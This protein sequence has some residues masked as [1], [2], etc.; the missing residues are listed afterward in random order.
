LDLERFNAGMAQML[1]QFSNGSVLDYI[2]ALMGVSRLPSDT[3]GCVVEFQLVPSHAQVL[4]P[5][6]TR[7][8]TADGIHIFEVLD[9]LTIEANELSVS[10]LVTA[11]TAGAAANGIPIGDINTILD[12]YAWISSVSNTTI[13]DGGADVET[14][15]HLRE[16]VLLAPSQ[17]SV[18][19]PTQAYIFHAKGA[20]SLIVDVSVFSIIPG[21]VYIIPLCLD[22]QDY[23]QVLDDIYNACNSETVRPLSDT[24]IAAAPSELHYGLNVEVTMFAGASATDVQTEVY[25][26]ISEYAKEKSQRL[27]LDIV[28]SHI[29]QR[30]RTSQVYDLSVVITDGNNNPITPEEMLVVQDDYVPINDFII[31][32]VIG[33][34]VG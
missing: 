30:A 11:Q 26:I 17:F 13:T 21:T 32:S 34:N 29:I 33:E 15:E 24:V 27:G 31:V 14:D 5:M 6:G 1:V 22:M 23:T 4:L 20:N 28:R 7:V 19:G 12:P 9:D 8:S 25:D 18:A 2:A 10:V 16:R 3:A